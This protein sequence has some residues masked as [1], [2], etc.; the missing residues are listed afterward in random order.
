M[1]DRHEDIVRCGLNSSSRHM[2]LM[3]QDTG[4][5]ME[6][7]LLNHIF[8]PFF[9]TKGDKGTGLGLATVYGIVSQHGGHSKVE[10]ELEKGTTFKVFLPVV[11]HVKTQPQKVTEEIK[12]YQGTEDIVLVEDDTSV[13]E[14]VEEVLGRLGYTIRAVGN[15]PDAL[16]ILE[17]EKVDLLLMLFYRV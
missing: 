17:K 1:V 15:A 13:K 16:K 6:S 4:C 10:S 8:E 5:G 2:V 7:D 11:D 12:H 3:V 14:M 9:S